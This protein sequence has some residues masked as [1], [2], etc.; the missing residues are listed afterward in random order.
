[1]LQL[2]FFVFVATAEVFFFV[3]Y[4]FF[5]FFSFTAS[6]AALGR[7]AI[8]FARTHEQVTMW[9][10]AARAKIHYVCKIL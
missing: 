2:F 10:Y 4:N 5:K 3:I 1:L 6:R 7:T 8:A 9:P